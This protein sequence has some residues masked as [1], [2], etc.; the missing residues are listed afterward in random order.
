MGESPSPQIPALFLDV[1]Y[2]MIGLYYLLI[3]CL[4]L[5][6]GVSLPDYGWREF[7]DIWD[8]DSKGGHENEDILDTAKRLRK[9]LAEGYCG[10]PLYVSMTTI[11][12]RFHSVAATVESIVQGE[13]LPTEIFVFISEDSFLLDQGITHEYLKSD[14]TKKLRDIR[15]VYPH[16]HIVY[17]KNIGPHRKLLPLLGNKWNE[18]CLLLTVDDH[19]L[20]PK[21]MLRDMMEYYHDSGGT[22]VVARRARRVGI[23]AGSPPWSATPYANANK[24][25]LWPETRP[26]R[27]EMLMLPTGTGGV[28]YRPSFFH[29]VVFTP[30]MWEATKTGDDLLFRLGTM[31]KGIPVVTTCC[32]DQGLKAACPPRDEVKVA[33]REQRDAMRDEVR[34]VWGVSDNAFTDSH[35][36]TL[37]DMG[38]VLKYGADEEEPE[39]EKRER[40]SETGAGRRER[41]EKDEKEEEEED[42]RRA[43]R[44]RDRRRRKKEKFMRH[45]QGGPDNGERQGEGEGEGEGASRPPARRRRSKNKHRRRQQ[46]VDGEFSAP[47]FVHV[48]GRPTR[49]LGDQA[50]EVSLATKF[51]NIGGNDAMWATA[52]AHLHARGIL[53]FNHILATFGGEERGQCLYSSAL[54][55]NGPLLFSGLRAWVQNNFWDAECGVHY[56]SV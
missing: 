29:P 36:Q 1:V 22:A 13:I 55:G 23:C 24:R 50:K 20:Y 37:R 33:L 8:V 28:L 44:L 12:S 41:P 46:E 9:G 30:E 5:Q 35:A 40:F 6:K 32:L 42:P 21:R 3:L 43:S 27:R 26:A 31:A 16:I 25:G 38:L 19:L 54:I 10:K 51:N 11:D 15:K 7:K 14:A 52:T 4:T 45:H 47:R 53:D 56:C 2:T 34:K 17:V 18:D 39:G 49:G 48:T